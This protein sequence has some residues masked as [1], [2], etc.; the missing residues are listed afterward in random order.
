[1]ASTALTVRRRLL[2]P[3]AA[4]RVDGKDGTN[5]VDGVNGTNGDDGAQG[6]RGGAWADGR[7]PH[8]AAGHDGVGMCLVRTSVMS[9]AQRPTV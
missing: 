1:M 6:E 4:M 5:G 3:L 8:G 9:M 7:D 2:V